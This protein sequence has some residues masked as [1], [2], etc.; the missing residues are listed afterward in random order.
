MFDTAGLAI[1]D[2][3]AGAGSVFVGLGANYSSNPHAG[4]VTNIG[5]EIT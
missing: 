2:L 4:T 5:G 1:Q 3:N